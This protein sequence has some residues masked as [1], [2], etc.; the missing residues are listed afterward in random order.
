MLLQCNVGETPD[1][2]TSTI[3]RGTSRRPSFKA[4]N[5]DICLLTVTLSLYI[6]SIMDE[7]E[8]GLTLEA[9][10]AEVGLSVRAVRFYITEK[11]LPPL[12]SRGKGAVWGEEHL[13]R[14]RLIRR[15][16]ERRMALAEIRD[17]LASLSVAEIRALLEEEDQQAQALAR[18]LREPSAKEYLSTLLR[19]ARA[20][21]APAPPS[22]PL[23]AP[24]TATLGAP[25]PPA[26]AQNPTLDSAP[27]GYAGKA[28]APRVL[29]ASPAAGPPVPAF[30]AK[31]FAPA[32]DLA[33]DS[34]TQTEVARAAVVRN[35]GPVGW[36]RHLLAPG[37]ELHVEESALP[38]RRALVDRLLAA[39][40]AASDE[41]LQSQSGLE[42]NP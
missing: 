5:I 35:A 38:A 23:P 2:A 16:T 17:R 42:R 18:T 15:L 3:P 13:L 12:G 10:A 20:G 1:P 34:V 27:G 31:R 4:R 9:L 33:E 41:E 14:L 11:L 19:Q 40:D 21:R 37:V 30:A 24:S 36:L 29:P 28:S 8:D 26:P 7:N 22:A 32:R 25:P 39:A 6:L